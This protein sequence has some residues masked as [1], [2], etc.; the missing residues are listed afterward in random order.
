MKNDAIGGM[1]REL[2]HRLN[3][4]WGKSNGKVGFKDPDFGSFC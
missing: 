2:C 3:R 4:F 1:V